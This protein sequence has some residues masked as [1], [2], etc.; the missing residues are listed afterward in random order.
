MLTAAMSV[1]K[2]LPESLSNKIAAGE[3][4]ERPAS[5]VK[6]LVENAI[7]AGATQ[8]TVQ[9]ERGGLSLIRVSDNGTGMSR[10]DA[11]LSLERHA[12]SKLDDEKSLF[13]IST[14]GF[15]G[16]A[17]PSIASVSNFFLV[18]RDADSEVGTEINVA[19]GKIKDVRDVGAP[20]GTM[21]EARQ[22]FFNIPA[23]RKFLKS[24]ET[25]MGHIADMMTAFALCRHD[26]HFR[27]SHDE[28]T[29]RNWPAAG[30]PLDRIT[31]ALGRDTRNNL[32]ELCLSSDQVKISGWI[33]APHITRRSSQKIYLFV[34]GRMVKDRGLQYALFEGYRGRL[35][36]GTYPVAAVF[37]TVPFD[38]VDVNV[39][40]TKNEVRFV[41]QKRVYQSLKTAVEKVWNAEPVLPWERD[42]G[43]PAPRQQTLTSVV[44]ESTAAYSGF[45]RRH[46]PGTIHPSPEP[47]TL[48]E[49]NQSAETVD[50]GIMP[51]A[52]VRRDHAG[53]PFL[54][55][56]LMIVGQFHN[57]YIVC[58]SDREI[59]MIDQHAAHERVVF[60]KLLKRVEARQPVSQG[61]LVPET[62][63]L[64][65]REAAALDLMLTVLEQTG[66]AVERFGQNTFVIKAVPEL[67]ADADAGRLVQ[68]LAGKMA[69]IGLAPDMDAKRDEF[70]SVMACH[71]AIRAN[72]RLNEKE[73]RALL[74]QMAACD[75]PW[76]CP[77]GRPTTIHWSL[78]DIEKLFK[79][80][81]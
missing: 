58:E 62:V 30:R 53:Q 74:E 48:P 40:P 60:E 25:E 70:L 78:R 63:E 72:R 69:E 21:A 56:G 22:L 17:I 29:A 47:M 42:S 26:I 51:T 28:K 31:D 79:R 43:Y 65:F 54:F 1:I 8:I 23:R 24:V 77:H 7:D 15:R 71:G 36:K 33:G 46:S 76:H 27:L 75:N 5:V 55:S 10:D 12:T 45:G 16:E 73:M 67:I 11:L 57:T 80:I 44:A 13:A 52:P 59:F 81:V 38:R 14:L 34:N 18:T 68:E 3:V 2:I 35:V 61:L 4:V 6:E 32:Y 37:I 9:V 20:V 50:I 64:T 41:D 49:R 39:H 66:L 19:G